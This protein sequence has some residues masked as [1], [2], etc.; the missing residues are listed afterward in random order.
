MAKVTTVITAMATA[1]AN[2][3]ERAFLDQTLRR[4][5]SKKVTDSSA[6]AG[7]GSGKRGVA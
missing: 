5:R 4:M 3:S 6:S 7:A 2:P 1:A